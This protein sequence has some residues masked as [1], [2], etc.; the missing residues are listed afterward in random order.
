[1]PMKKVNVLMGNCRYVI[2]WQP[3]IRR[4]WGRKKCW[5][6]NFASQQK[7][8]YYEAEAAERWSPF[9]CHQ[10]RIPTKNAAKSKMIFTILFLLE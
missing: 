8:I 7:P 9:S 10:R 3:C 6:A 5:D 1:M 4:Q 2:L